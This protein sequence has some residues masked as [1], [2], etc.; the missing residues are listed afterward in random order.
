MSDHALTSADATLL[1][2]AVRGAGSVAMHYFRRRPKVWEKAKNDPVSEAD[3]AVNRYLKARLEAARPAYGWLSEESEDDPRRFG[4]DRVWVVDP[5]DGTRAFIKGRPDFVISAALVD[6]GR[7]VLG[8]VFRPALD[9]LFEA[10]L[11]TGARLNGQPI[12]ISARAA[13]E[14]GGMAGAEDYFR[15]RTVWPLPWPQLRFQPCNSIALRV[16]LVACGDLEAAVTLRPKNDWDIA[17]AD[18][19]LSEAGGLLDSGEGRP[20]LYNGKLPRLPRIIATNGHVHAAVMA[21]VDAA[22]SA[23]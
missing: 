6:C 9:Q 21:R 15:S 17:A 10:G 13:L 19:I 5:I 16:C 7:P 4:C 14:A 20:H 11:G 22:V 8:I 12:Q 3:M 18:L 1:R 23:A 2:D